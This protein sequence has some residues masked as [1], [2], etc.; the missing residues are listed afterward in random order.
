MSNFDEN[1]LLK[2]RRQFSGKEKYRLFLQQLDRLETENREWGKKYTNLLKVHTE[3]LEKLKEL[4]QLRPRLEQVEAEL[5]EYKATDTDKKF[6]RK[7]A[8]TLMEN[9]KIAW[10][11][12]YWELHRKLQQ[13]ESAK[14]TG[15]TVGSGE[16]SSTPAG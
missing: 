10:E 8:Y 12:R 13:Y 2:I 5:G 9:E 1:I 14:S 7:K 4:K 3:T 16:D 11:M 15:T 6:V